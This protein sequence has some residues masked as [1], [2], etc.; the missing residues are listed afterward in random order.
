MKNLIPSSHTSPPRV[1]RS[2]PKWHL[3]YYLLAIFDVLTVATSLSLNH[4][5]MES[6]EQS[7]KVNQMW[8][9]RLQSYSELAQLAGAVNAPGNDIFDSPSIKLEKE[10]LNTGVRRFQEKMTA[11]RQ[12]I[13]ISTDPIHRE[14]ILK[15]LNQIDVTMAEMLQEANLIFSYF[16]QNQPQQAAQGMAS[17][18]RTFAKVN[19]ALENLRRNV[20]PIQQQ[21]LDQQKQQA[22]LLKIYLRMKLNR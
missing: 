18:D 5:L 2:K 14:T 1:C 3:V 6:Y 7:V 19:V 13:H 17:M 16:S 15:D 12:N 4:R 22:S 11:I 8:A 9:E 10:R 21:N 20:A